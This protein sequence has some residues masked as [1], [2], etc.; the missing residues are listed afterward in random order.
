M[1]LVIRYRR[2]DTEDEVFI[3]MEPG[4]DGQSLLETLLVLEGAE[5]I[6]VCAKQ[7]RE[8]LKEEWRSVVLRRGYEGSFK[9]WLEAEARRSPNDPSEY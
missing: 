5:V 7:T 4:G 1:Q 3:G 8:E 2:G 9:Q 6:S